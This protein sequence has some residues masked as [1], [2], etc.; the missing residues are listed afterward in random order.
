V[1]IV[2]AAWNPCIVRATKREKGEITGYV[3]S[4]AHE[5]VVHV[6]KVATEFVGLTHH[7]IWDVHCSTWPVVGGDQPDEPL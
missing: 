2:V 7:D 4:Q 3:E 5:A 1:S 6:E